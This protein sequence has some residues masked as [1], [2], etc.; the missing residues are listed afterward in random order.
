[1]SDT[2]DL[3]ALL[4]QPPGMAAIEE[5][6]AEPEAPS[7]E[8]TLVD[9]RQPKP[10]P[11]AAPVPVPSMPSLSIKSTEIPCCPWPQPEPF[12]PGPP[13]ERP[14][15]DG[16]PQDD[17][18]PEPS[19]VS[20]FVYSMKG[21]ESPTLF[22]IWAALFAV[23]AMSARQAQFHWEIGSFYPN[24]Y[25]LIVGPPAGPHKGAAMG[26]VAR[27]LEALPTFLTPVSRLL[28]EEKRIP[29]LSSRATSE[30]IFAALAP[31][32]K[33]F[34]VEG[35]GQIVN[36]NFGSRAYVWA[37]EFATFLNSKKYAEG[38]VDALAKWYD[39]EDKDNETLA[40][41]KVKP[42]QNIFFCLAGAMT[43]GHVARLPAEAFTGGLMSRVV[44]VC[45]ERPFELF[46]RPIHYDGYPDEPFLLERLGYLAFQCR[47]EYDFTPEAAAFYDSY[48]MASREKT[49]KGAVDTA[50]YARLRHEHLV[51][52]VAMLMRMAEYRPG[53]D[54]TVQNL[55][56]AISL[57]EYTYMCQTP[58]TESVGVNE[59]GAE[60]LKVRRIIQTAGRI[61]R[62]HLQKRLS[63]VGILAREMDLI[64]EQLH[65]QNEVCY[66]WKDK[67]LNR[68]TP[69]R[70]PDEVYIYTGPKEAL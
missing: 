9:D 44:M 69:S 24:M 40:T 11:P 35:T 66:E 10:Q 52:R 68:A 18:I 55:E 27:L 14:Y 42:L 56:D 4:P 54:I 17:L 33:I 47:G 46:P 38:L 41:K 53:H 67:P 50:A 36:R 59:I 37:S 28:A 1:M 30:G 20:D 62:L 45:Q 39:C 57:L 12:D 16:D 49:L 26:R 5:A 13:K 34:T 31:Q 2:T 63:R 23:S 19:F 25:L 61:D 60:F 32:K 22:N 15:R 64:L 48:Y 51:I 70:Q 3:T 6:P 21:C 58:V 7:E 65:T 43:P 29:C 8:P